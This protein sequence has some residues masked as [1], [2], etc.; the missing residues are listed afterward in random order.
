MGEFFENFIKN[1]ITSREKLSYLNN[2]NLKLIQVPYAYRVRF[3]KK[4]KELKNLENM[5]KFLNEKGKLSKIKLKKENNESK[6]EEI[7]I[8]KEEDDK[9]VS[10]EEMRKTFTQAIYDF[11]KTHTKFH[12]DNNENEEDYQ[13]NENIEQE[14]S[15][16]TSNI[17]SNE[18]KTSM[19][20]NK[21]SQ[22]M[23]TSKFDSEIHNNEEDQVE[24]GEYI[25][26]KNND[27]KI[28][29][30]QLLPLH[31]KKILCYQCWTV[32]LRKDCIL[33]YGRPFCSLKC[34]DIYDNINYT[35]C[36]YCS[37]KIK[38]VDSLPSFNNRNINYCS[39]ECLEKIEPERK[40]W[41]KKNLVDD[42]N[43]SVSS[44]I[45]NISEKQVD[46]LDL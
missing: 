44:S 37:K 24:V 43:E 5:K 42:D 9:E 10:N 12:F 21:I 32:I 13:V 40:N 26:S 46:I 2:D 35:K 20:N 38:Y 30:K 19:N 22:E 14:L 17:N 6:Y 23:S 7:Y 28:K 27:E 8:P 4:M 25:E 36:Q 3:L 1:G 18:T 39:L 41:M 16:N 34:F 33:K 31:C 15:N 45:S 29:I 11:Q